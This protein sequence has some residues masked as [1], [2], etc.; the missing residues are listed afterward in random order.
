MNE[1]SFTNPKTEYVSWL[2]LPGI[3]EIDYSAW[4]GEILELVKEIIARFIEYLPM[5]V[6]ILLLLACVKIIFDWDLKEWWKRIKYILIGVALMF[7]CIYIV[8]II[9]TIMTWAPLI[10]IQ[11]HKYF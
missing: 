3:K 5:I 7:L 2:D 10:H 9:S 4:W 6:L 1:S 11:F 8:N